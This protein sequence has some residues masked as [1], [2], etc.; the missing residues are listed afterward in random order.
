MSEYQKCSS[1]L[2]ILLW[3]IYSTNLTKSLQSCHRV[4]AWVFLLLSLSVT[5][6]SKIIAMCLFVNCFVFLYFLSFCRATKCF[7]PDRYVE[8]WFGLAVTSRLSAKSEAPGPS[9]WAN[10]FFCRGREKLLPNLDSSQLS[11]ALIIGWGKSFTWKCL[12]PS[13]D[14]RV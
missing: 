1:A 6:I 14:D 11:Y 12:S 10:S 7:Y 13:V 5:S 8:I 3:L 2:V 4:I 9:W